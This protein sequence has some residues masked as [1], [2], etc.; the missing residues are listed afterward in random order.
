MSSQAILR[1]GGAGAPPRPSSSNTHTA[2]YVIQTIAPPRAGA[3]GRGGGVR[4]Y[5]GER[6][7]EALLAASSVAD[8]DEARELGLGSGDGRVRAGGGD[9]GVGLV[10]AELDV[11]LAAFKM[12]KL[13]LIYQVR[14]TTT[15]T[16]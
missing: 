3:G 14:A 10:A 13:K 9:G 11:V 16:L 2:V 4:V 1:S 5:S 15:T 7:A 12:L 6:R 8:P